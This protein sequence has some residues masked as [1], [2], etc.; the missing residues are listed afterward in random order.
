MIEENALEK[1]D[2][3]SIIETISN[4]L[5]EVNIDIPNE[6]S[7]SNQLVD[8]V[9]L[10]KLDENITL[11]K[12][13][14]SFFK[15]FKK[16]VS[17]QELSSLSYHLQDTILS[18]DNFDSETQELLQLSIN[19]FLKN[20]YKHLDLYPFVYQLLQ[21]K[22]G[23]ALCQHFNLNMAKLYHV[24]HQQPKLKSLTN[25]SKISEKK[26]IQK[27]AI[28]SFD[29]VFNL[30]SLIA[31]CQSVEKVSVNFLL[32]AILLTHEDKFFNILFSQALNKI[33]KIKK[34]EIVSFLL[35][36]PQLPS[37]D[38]ASRHFIFNLEKENTIL[39]NFIDKVGKPLCLE[40]EKF[41]L[42]MLKEYKKSNQAYQENILTQNYFKKNFNLLLKNTTLEFYQ[43]YYIE[44]VKDEKLLKYDKRVKPFVAAGTCHYNK[45]I[46]MNINEINTTKKWGRLWSKICIENIFFHELG[47]A[48]DNA[49]KYQSHISYPK[50]EALTHSQYAQN[51]FFKKVMKKSFKNFKPLTKKQKERFA[52]YVKP[53]NQDK[54]VSSTLPIHYD[55]KESIDTPNTFLFKRLV[56]KHDYSRSQCEGF[57]ECFSHIITFLL[58]GYDEG[59]YFSETREHSNLREFIKIMKPTLLYLLKHIKWEEVGVPKHL[60]VTRK[61]EFRRLIEHLDNMPLKNKKFTERSPKIHRQRK[62]LKDRYHY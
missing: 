36:H 8:L 25:F 6:S 21:T 53:A 55:N 46:K 42:C 11:P 13:N 27:N 57:A 15:N 7:F 58:N 61:I 60:L 1:S 47:H 16:P 2:L 38:F 39:T 4:E 3:L 52:Y 54:L 35:S 56:R 12:K 44:F 49:W 26:L 43:S 9:E 30:A 28:Y 17:Y 19:Y 29:Y 22:S 40:N 41:H 34:Y 24:C 62:M 48:F 10:N 59:T 31:S 32:L 18:V 50:G 5:S 45:K 20:K 37:N 51:K 23:Q 14:V 33:S